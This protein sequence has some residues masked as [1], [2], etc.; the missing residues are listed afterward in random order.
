MIASIFLREG[1]MRSFHKIIKGTFILTEL[2]AP[3][4]NYSKQIREQPS[5]NKKSGLNR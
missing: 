3:R 4:E 2:A 5:G 1:F